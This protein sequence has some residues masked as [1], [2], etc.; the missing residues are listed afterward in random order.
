MLKAI[1]D[2]LV[3]NMEAFFVFMAASTCIRFGSNL[4]FVYLLSPEAFAISGL[5]ASTFFIANLISD[6]GFRPF[7]LRYQKNMT[8]ELLDTVWSL[9]LLRGLGLMLTLAFLAGYIAEATGVE[10]LETVL[11]V[12]SVLFCFSGMRSLG[13]MMTQRQDN[14]FKPLYIELAVLIGTKV[15][16]IIVAWV[17]HS[18][19][20]FVVGFFFEAI[21][22][23]IASYILY[24]NPF[25][26]FRIK[27]GYASELWQ[28]A[29]VVI[30]SSLLTIAMMQSDKFILTSLLSLSQ[31][32]LYYLA[33]S[34]AKLPEMFVLRYT[35][36]VFVPFI[37]K[38]FREHPESISAKVYQKKSFYLTLACVLTG[39]LAGSATLLIG[40]VYPAQYA[41]AAIYLFFLL[42][43]PI[44]SA[45]SVPSENWL[46]IMQYDRIVLENNI[47]RCI[48]ILCG[49]FLGVH[50][51]GALGVVI[52]FA[53][54]DLL[55]AVWGMWRLYCADM[56][57]LKKELLLPFVAVVT[58]S[59]VFLISSRIMVYFNV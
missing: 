53:T 5:L 56:L 55:P 2:R 48:W 51:L 49:S 24:S 35:R 47:M 3:G 40:L 46:L 42:M 18:Y 52:A 10:E 59:I 9:R 29:K 14:I 58:A 22:M 54:R 32:G 25:R 36:G 33:I 28:L 45:M 44:F 31:V 1:T 15:V 57:E 43:H 12:C 30:P 4:V 27:R 37:A 6:A 16:T 34:I 13:E 38:A 50:Y 20:A 8:N 41:G 23:L 39:I 21:A 17:T 7:V 19:W 11:L 26:K